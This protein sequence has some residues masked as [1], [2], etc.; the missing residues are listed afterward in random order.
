MLKK[1][2]ADSHRHLVS[3]LA[4]Y[5]QFRRF[6]LVFHWADADLQDYWE[7]KNPTPAVDHETILWMAEQCEGIAG[8]LCKIH[9]YLTPQKNLAVSEQS[10]TQLF[11]RHGDIKPANILWFLDPCDPTSRGTLQITDFGLAEFS[12]IHRSYKPKSKVATSPSYRPPECD[13]YGGVIGLSYDIWT[14]GCLYL[15][16]TTWLLG[17]WNLVEKFTKNRESFDREL[18]MPTDTFF[19]IEKGTAEARIKPAVTDVRLSHSNNISMLTQSP[20]SLSSDCIRMNYVVTFSTISS[21]LF[22][23]T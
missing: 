4:T 20:F 5:E 23:W 2:S 16:F 12:A 22:V 6:Y 21:S 19:E 7:K 10:M 14:M 13:L 11:G 9:H 3:L 8:G 17:G 18:H 1:F 15:E